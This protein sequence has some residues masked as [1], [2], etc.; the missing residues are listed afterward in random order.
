MGCN[1]IDNVSHEHNIP[2]HDDSKMANIEMHACGFIDNLGVV[3]INQAKV[4]KWLEKEP[5]KLRA[6]CTIQIKNCSNPCEA[7]T[8]QDQKVN[9]VFW[10]QLA[11]A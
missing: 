5:V 1:L 11:V 3:A 10:E 6:S 2:N 7:E 4:D 9:W 8:A